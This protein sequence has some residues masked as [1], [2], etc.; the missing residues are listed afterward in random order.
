MSTF[1]NKVGI[2]MGIS[3]NDL[4]NNNYNF[5]VAGDSYFNGNVGIGTTTT[6]GAKLKVAGNTIIDGYVGVG[7][8]SHIYGEKLNVAGSVNATGYL[9]NGVPLGGE[10]W[11]TGSGLNIYYS[12]GNVSIG[13]ANANYTLNVCG[14][15]GAKEVIVDATSWCDFK[16]K[17]GHKRMTA[18]EKLAYFLIYGHL[19]EMDPGIEIE[20]NG[21]KVAKNMRGMIWNIEE[22]SLDIIDLYKMILEI[23]KENIQLKQDNE[24]LKKEIEAIKLK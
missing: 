15:I 17:P 22:N 12:S 21:L 6:Q 3:V 2:G 13:T 8:S 10:K 7:I 18:D 16:L 11:T 4:I 19:P 1:G 5:G 14:T 23:K 20:T 9:L 24:L